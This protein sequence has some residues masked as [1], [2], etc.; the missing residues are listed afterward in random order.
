MILNKSLPKL[1]L[2]ALL[3]VLCASSL[4]EGR[5]RNRY[6]GHRSRPRDTRV[7]IEIYQP[8][9][10]MVW[11]PKRPGMTLF[12]IEIYL[13]HEPSMMWHHDSAEE[14]TCDIC[15]NTTEVS[16]GKFILRNDDAI[17][18]GGDRLSYNVIKQKV[19]GS[20]YISA[21]N[22][23]F[24]AENRIRSTCNRQVTTP[25]TTDPST[26]NMLEDD[27]SVLENVVYDVFQQC[28]NVSDITNNLFI[29]VRPASDTRMDSKQLYASTKATL[30]K[31][32]PQ[33]DWNLTL[34]NAYYYD[35]GVAFEV[36]TLIDKLKILRRAKDF[37]QYTIQ[38]LDEIGM[39]DED[40]E[41][42]VYDIDSYE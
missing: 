33:F 27:I 24:V 29:N 22:E 14:V 25:P 28:R 6:R 17:I 15:M 39:V 5:R 26:V 9:G 10:I 11:Y 12:G 8:K 13:N 37:V 36:R 2:L 41:I 4:A 23:F 21:S 34:T 40:N 32:L 42:T 19:N 30:E 31:L 38:D 20:A 18:R 3:L 1:C 7:R 35:D 16:Y